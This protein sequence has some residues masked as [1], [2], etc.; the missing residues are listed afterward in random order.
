VQLF[1][2]EEGTIGGLNLY[3]TSH[4]DIDPEA[5]TIAERFAAQARS[6]WGTPATRRVSTRPSPRDRRSAR[7]SAS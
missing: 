1:L 6:L 7:P 5:E 3:S 2:G 4:E